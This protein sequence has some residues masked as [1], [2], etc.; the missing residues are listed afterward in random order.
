[1]KCSKKQQVH[2]CYIDI[3]FYLNSKE[4]LMRQIEMWKTNVLKNSQGLEFKFSAILSV[5]LQ[6]SKFTII[7]FSILFFSHVFQY[8]VTQRVSN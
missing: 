8:I 5:F 6:I 7:D 3:N 4:H 1:M 2:V